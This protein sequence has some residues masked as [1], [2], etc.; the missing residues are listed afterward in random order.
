MRVHGQ[1]LADGHSAARRK[2]THVNDTIVKEATTSV[3]AVRL[4]L[5]P[6]SK[7][8]RHVLL[9]L[10]VDFLAPPSCTLAR[11]NVHDAS[12]RIT[13]HHAAP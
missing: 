9:T 5:D 4:R 8:R 1:T 3:V 12:K 7:H 6:G 2:M 13:A 11:Y 10:L